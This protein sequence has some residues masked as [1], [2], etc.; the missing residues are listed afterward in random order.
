[1]L[2]ALIRTRAIMLLLLACISLSSSQGIFQTSSL[3]NMR[4]S[5]DTALNFDLYSAITGWNLS[6]SLTGSYTPTLSNS[7]I[8]IQ[9]NLLKQSL[10]KKT[11]TSNQLQSYSGL[12]IDSVR[13]YL[14]TVDE[15]TLN[16]WNIKSLP[17]ISLVNSY[18]IS[19]SGNVFQTESFRFAGE[20]NTEIYY[21]LTVETKSPSYTVKIFDCS[22]IMNITL[23]YGN[24]PGRAISSFNRATFYQETSGIWGFFYYA[25]GID[26]YQFNMTGSIT[27]AFV[28]SV[29]AENFGIED[30]NPVSISFYA[31]TGYFCD[32]NEGL[33]VFSL[34]D[35]GSYLPTFPII[36]RLPAPS[37]VG[38]IFSCVIN[39]DYLTVDTTG[40]TI[41]YLLPSLTQWKIFPM[42][43]GYEVNEVYGM[44][45]SDS[46]TA[47][48]VQTMAS[49][50]YSPVSFRIYSNTLDYSQ[51]MLAD[52]PIKTFLQGDS[53]NNNPSFAMYRPYSSQKN[54]VIVS[55]A[56]FMYVYLLQP[57]AY[58]S[59]PKQSVAY[60]YTGTL[61]VTNGTANSSYD[62]ALQGIS[63]NSTLLYTSKQQY[64]GQNYAAYTNYSTYILT[65]ENKTFI[66]YVPLSNY[67]SGQN[68]TYNFSV[69]QGL[70]PYDNITITNPPKSLLTSNLALPENTASN[71]GTFS[72]L[73]VDLM[74]D[75]VVVML[76][77]SVQVNFFYQAVNISTFEISITPSYLTPS[78]AVLHA[79]DNFYIIVESDGTNPD[80]QELIVQWAVY[81]VSHTSYK[82]I[83]TYVFTDRPPSTKIECESRNFYS[84]YGSVIDVYYFTALSGNFS[85]KYVNTISS[86]TI[87]PK[88][89][90]L[91]ITFKA[92]TNLYVYDYFKGLIQITTSDTINY[93]TFSNVTFPETYDVQIETDGSNNLYVYTN[94]L[95]NEVIYKVSLG[96]LN[97]VLMTPFHC[98][99][100]LAIS[101]NSPFFG[102]LCAEYQYYSV[103]IYDMNAVSYES[104]YTEIFP[105]S[106]GTF[107]LGSSY[108]PN[109]VLYFI[110]GQTLKTYILGQYG[111]STWMPTY[112]VAYRPQSDSSLVTWARISVSFNSTVFSSSYPLSLLITASNNYMSYGENIAYTLYNTADFIQ[113]NPSFDPISSNLTS[114]DIDLATSNFAEAL[115]LNAFKGNNIDFAFQI[116]NTANNI[117]SATES[118]S[119]TKAEFC[120]ENKTYEFYETSK[121]FYDFDISGD[122][123]IGTDGTSAYLYTLNDTSLIEVTSIFINSGVEC[124]NIKFLPN[125]PTFV[126]SCT[127]NTDFNNF[128]T[129]ID[130]MDGQCSSNNITVGYAT[131]FMKTYKSSSTV[132]M[133]YHYEGTTLSI[134]SIS[135]TGSEVSCV[136]AFKLIKHVTQNTLGVSSFNLVDIGFWR[137][138]MFILVEQ[139]LGLLYV[140]NKTVGLKPTFTL[141]FTFFPSSNVVSVSSSQIASSSFLSD[142]QTVLLIMNSADVYKVSLGNMAVI[143]HYPKIMQGG[144]VPVNK[145]AAVY[146]DLSLLVYPVFVQLEAGVLRVLNYS[147]DPSSGIYK[148]RPLNFTYGSNRYQKIQFFP[149]YPAVLAHTVNFYN[150]A[151]FSGPAHLLLIRDKPMGYI[152]KSNGKYNGT[153]ALVG[154]SKSETEQFTP[155]SYYYP[156]SS[157]PANDIADSTNNYG[158]DWNTWYFWTILGLFS[159]VLVT[160]GVS[161]YVCMKKKERAYSSLSIGLTTVNP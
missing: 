109:G 161:I 35:L 64:P 118:C 92:S 81:N 63:P 20:N 100:P 33:V 74:Y 40:G 16:V 55:S 105:G 87:S 119:N 42:N 43:P 152:Y 108:I 135:L 156:G 147:S 116:N 151:E 58:L 72:V 85:L 123:F 11:E 143:T 146:E 101:L 27:G 128:I 82:L 114:G 5:S 70:S 41:V 76:Q 77:N 150:L 46:Y 122:Y 148:D 66:S 39:E 139:S 137:S 51:A 29:T 94:N 48:Y 84:L 83:E 10:V 117:V 71:S 98:S 104:F 95:I 3:S 26:I 21:V 158:S 17:S 54:Y 127:N 86:D 106:Q 37:Q 136:C 93:A 2:V 154:Y 57:A 45:S 47:G 23:A 56:N 141:S 1:M 110:D 79:T 138:T 120:L 38:T 121:S 144:L 96:S 18:S 90:F 155:V 103:Q 65:K 149:S 73:S 67:Y 99:F 32:E 50:S 111:D 68:V 159:L 130:P 69:S 59:F 153:L 157:N 25:S 107:A 34:S 22:N 19:T 112:P 142:K 30:L 125:A 115:P 89:N 28:T 8:S 14:Y 15:N 13:D 160:S 4:T 52:I 60:N 134:Y 145:I 124:M 75:I 44:T 129:V 126:I 131:Q 113:S 133:L 24:L 7:S 140:N 80:N 62:L 78:F 36:R 88:F 6:F 12:S 97:S 132:F 61:F 9:G 49:S 31:Q 102:V 53:S 91:P